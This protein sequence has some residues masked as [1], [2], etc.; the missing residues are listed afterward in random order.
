MILNHPIITQEKKL[1]LYCCKHALDGMVDVIHPRC[2]EPGC[3][4]LPSYNNPEEKGGL[5]CSTHAL[6]GMVDVVS[7]RCVEPGCNTNQNL[8]NQVKK[9]DYIVIHIKK[10]GWLM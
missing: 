7:K 9:V 3:D 4:T 5:Y 2:I 10:M 8:I 6:D 1:G